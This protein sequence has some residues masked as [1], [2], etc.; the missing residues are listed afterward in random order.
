MRR[1]DA[2]V[3]EGSCF[4]R[5]MESPR[6]IAALRDLGTWFFGVPWVTRNLAL[7]CV[8]IHV[9]V[10]AV[11]TSASSVASRFCFAADAV[12]R[13]L[14]VHRIVVSPLLH[15]GVLHLGFNM[16]TWTT[17]RLES[18]MGSQR[19][20]N[21]VLVSVAVAATMQCVLAEVLALLPA[22]WGLQ[23]GCSVG[24]SGVCFTVM[25]VEAAHGGR[26]TRAVGPFVVPA[27]VAPWVMLL[28]LQLLLPGHS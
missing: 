11:S 23:P 19:F 16:V 22:S 13:E 18:T 25:A 5:C 24:L 17:N 20:L 26:T 8:L 7:L 12:V 28:V 4:R 3:G 10:L 6:S 27:S 9:V 14:A 1:P 2:S 21:L 15:T